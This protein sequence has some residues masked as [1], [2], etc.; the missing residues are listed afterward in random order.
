MYSLDTHA[1]VR[2][3]E[4][5]GFGSAQAEV[6]VSTI[7]RADEQIATKVDISRLDARITAVQWIQGIQTVLVV[8]LLVRVFGLV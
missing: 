3:L 1:A 2:N 4:A 8:A 6:I 5:A 7:A